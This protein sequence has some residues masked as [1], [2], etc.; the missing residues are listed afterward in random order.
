MKR[1]FQVL[2]FTPTATADATNLADGTHMDLGNAAAANMI[3]VTEIMETGL[4]AASAVNYMTVT[5]DSTLPATPS[6][7]AAPNSDG[8]LNGLAQA[9]SAAPIACVAATTKPQRSSQTTGLRLNLGFNAF[10]GI[11]KWVPAPG[12]EPKIIGVSVNVSN[13]NLSGFTG[14]AGGLMGAHIEY[15]LE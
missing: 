7:L 15:E 14:G 5:R 12:F 8:P 11:I 6:A 9:L 13:L 3:T 10:G 4:A 2:S 1:S